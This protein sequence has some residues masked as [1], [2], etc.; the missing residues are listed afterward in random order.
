MAHT[1]RVVV[2]GIGS[3]SACGWTANDLHSGLLSGISAIGAPTN[4]DTSGQRTSVAGEV[5]P[6]PDNV[7]EKIPEWEALSKSDRFAVAAAIEAV[8]RAQISDG[9]SAAGLFFGGSTG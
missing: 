1:V 8:E 9:L 6:A 7:V 2:T 4:F 5:P 3:V